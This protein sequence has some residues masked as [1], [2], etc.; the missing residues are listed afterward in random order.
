MAKRGI[1]AVR[2]IAL[3][4]AFVFLLS[5][6]PFG[7]AWAAEV[8]D[9]RIGVH[10]NYTRMV[11]ELDRP[12]GY[13][14]ERG[15]GRSEL[16]ITLDADSITRNLK[17]E[18]SLVESIKVRG[19]AKGSE[20]RVSLVRGGLSLKEMILV[21]PPRIVLDV[22]APKGQGAKVAP[23]KPPA[24]SKA[25]AKPK[26][27]PPTARPAAK[28][29]PKAVAKPVSKP[30]KRIAAGSRPAKPVIRAEPPAKPV[31]KKV[32]KKKEKKQAAAP[33]TASAA[34]PSKP[35]KALAPKKAVPAPVA[36]AAPPSPSD[37]PIEPDDSTGSAKQIIAVAGLAI[38]LVAWIMIRRRRGRVSVAATAPSEV[39]RDE[40]DAETHNPFA[41]LEPSPEE[42]SHI[43]AA[44]MESDSDD[45]SA[46]M[47]EDMGEVMG[48]AIGADGSPEEADSE[49][50]LFDQL[51]LDGS[52]AEESAPGPEIVEPAP[53]GLSPLDEPVIE[54]NEPVSSP[55]PA[56][57]G[58]EAAAEA[59]S[60]VR[61]LEERVASLQ[62]R[63]E[64]AVES[65]ERIER[66]MA[67]Q[68][69]ELRVQ[70]AAIARTQRAVRNIARSDEENHG[71][72]DSLPAD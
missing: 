42:Q 71:E 7:G 33:R 55:P 50:A 72:S 15:S 58:V 44:K 1:E 25:A 67:A 31:A 17:S 19:T 47:D 59:I 10:P 35:K 43:L 65:R 11:F 5:A 60:L 32:A 54:L 27:A 41:V 46:V 12:A 2:G 18:K 62:G 13:K 30:A 57:S 26:P 29:P 14:V 48:D 51:P 69:E 53:L 3:L 8:V 6:I 66:Q 63:L 9:V 21:D 38:V 70:R 4:W 39:D 20:A 52:L 56:E 40:A 49:Q 37:R 36:V 34:K 68:N 22:V 24:P 23:V 61:G 64:D 16:V 45:M 28:V